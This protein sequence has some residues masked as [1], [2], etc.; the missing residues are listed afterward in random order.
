MTV[1]L[2]G[3]CHSAISSDFQLGQ[4]FASDTASEQVYDL[5]EVAK[6]HPKPGDIIVCKSGVYKDVVLSVKFKGTKEK[7]I[8]IVAQKN[9]ELVL[10][11][12][13][14]VKISGEYCV[15]EGFH[16]KDINTSS[17]TSL[18][19]FTKGSSNCAFRNCKIDGK[20]SKASE[21]DS[22]W[23]SFYG[24]HNEVS[25]CTFL[26]KR[27][28][29][30]L[31]VV[32][33]EDGI[34][35]SHVIKDNYFTRPYTHY[36]ENGKA[37]NGQE[38]IRIGTSQ[39]SMTDGACTVSGNYFY[40]CDG[41]RAEII[42]NKSCKN[43]YHHNFFENSVGT[44][45][46]RHG[47]DCHVY[48]NYFVSNK[49]ADVGGVR[50]IGE[51]HIVENNKFLSLTGSGYMSAI[52]LV[53]GES[54]AALNGYWTVIDPLVKDNIFYNCRYGIVV[55]FSGRSTQDSAPTGSQF[56]NNILY[57]KNKSS[58]T[59]VYLIEM[60][61]SDIKWEN[62]AIFG[63]KCQGVQLPYTE[64]EPRIEDYSEIYNQIKQNAGIK[65]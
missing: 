18:M 61:Q 34:I 63:G 3:S 37:K 58:Y 62:N 10:M 36:D 43:V 15:V 12:S 23:V 6:L 7:P 64:N 32:W 9:G 4:N 39:Y 56:Q 5:T 49:K 20:S 31:M 27:N 8:K 13:S 44:L 54:N 52:C 60:S 42:S 14:A 35:P 17:K 50:I 55:N 2:W 48:D 29:G 22:K 25:N 40:N 41:E 46:L 1:L 30:C 11:G 57:S 26:D 38:T 65:W 19:T 45:T 59:P 24:S 51:R 21:V 47:N 53:R 33:L 28:M 16:W